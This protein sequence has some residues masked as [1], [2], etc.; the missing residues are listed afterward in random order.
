[1]GHQSTL[2][3][4]HTK[5]THT[6]KWNIWVEPNQIFTEN[7]PDGWTIADVERAA[8]NRYGG[9]VT[10]VS[11]A[12]LGGSD[13][14]RRSSG[15]SGGGLGALIW[16]GIGIA[17]ISAFGGGESDKSPAP[18]PQSAPIERSYTPAPAATPSYA[19]PA[20]PCVTANFE[21]C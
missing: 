4:I 14:P 20:G 6:M 15:G 8:D 9:K 19:N 3:Y 17:V 11:P 21:P 2:Y 18:A 16:I 7:Y 1:M 5:Q 10:C 13:A 12:G